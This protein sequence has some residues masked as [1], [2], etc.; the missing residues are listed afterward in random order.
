M[1][2]NSISS[3]SYDAGGTVASVHDIITQR[4]TLTAPVAALEEVYWAERFVRPL[5]RGVGP[6]LLIAGYCMAVLMFI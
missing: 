4:L 6:L 5:S 1:A 3:C 2:E